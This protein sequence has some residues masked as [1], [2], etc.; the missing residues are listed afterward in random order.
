MSKFQ[1]NISTAAKIEGGGNINTVANITVDE[2]HEYVTIMASK[3]AKMTVD[4]NS[5]ITGTITAAAGSNYTV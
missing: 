2:L 3:I 4:E 1:K 5:V